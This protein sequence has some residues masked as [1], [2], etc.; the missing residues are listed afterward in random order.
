MLRLVLSMMK[1]SFGIQIKIWH[2]DIEIIPL[3]YFK[4]PVFSK[5]HIDE[6]K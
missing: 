4:F 1:L 3:Q 2:T 5:W 6:L